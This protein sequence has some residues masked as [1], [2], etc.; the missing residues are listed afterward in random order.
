[1]SP[2]NIEIKLT[3]ITPS[4]A[5]MLDKRTLEKDLDTALRNTA[6]TVRADFRRTT[7]TWNR[8]PKFKITGPRNTGLKMEILISTNN[9]IYSYVT[10][11]TRAHLIPKSPKRIGS[12]AFP[13]KF[14][15]KTRP[16]IIGSRSGFRGGGTAF[17][18]QVKHPG[19][20]A[21]DFDKEIV[22][23][24]SGYLATQV[25]QAFLHAFVVGRGRR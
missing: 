1:M 15:S 9:E 21:R 6:K 12:L 14:K 13:K 18:K 20:K 7:K 23:R 25:N 24:R 17:A 16:R 3:S 2:A 5:K 11:G 4:R 22:K 10:R 19:S 8:R